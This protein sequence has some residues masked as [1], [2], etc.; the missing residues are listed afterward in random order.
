VKAAGLTCPFDKQ[1]NPSTAG[2]VSQLERGRQSPT[3]DML[4]RV[5]RI[6][7]TSASTIISQAEKGR[8]MPLCGSRCVKGQT[9]VGSGWGIRACSMPSQQDVLADPSCAD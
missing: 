7:G 1:R 4:L 5:C 8:A 3:V 2:K 9:K 6:L